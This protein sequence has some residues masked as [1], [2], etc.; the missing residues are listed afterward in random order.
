MQRGVS[1]VSIWEISAKYSAPRARTRRVAVRMWLAGALFLATGVMPLGV[2]A[3]EVAAGRTYYMQYCASCHGVEAD[4]HGYVAPALAH[5]PTDLRHLGDGNDT[6]LLVDSLVRVIDGRKVV[7]A[8]G[9]RQMPVWGQRFEDIK[10]EGAPR[11]QA[12]R[13]HINVLVAYLLSIQVKARP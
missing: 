10:A 4:G 6:S 1:E 3:D 8:H 9:E 11:E 13:A 12:V 7:T 2:F 5:P